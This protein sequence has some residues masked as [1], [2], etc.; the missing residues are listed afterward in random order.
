MTDKYDTLIAEKNFYR[1]LL[2][3]KTDIRKGLKK[4]AVEET[5]KL[6]HYIIS[7]LVENREID[8]ALTLVSNFLD[9]YDKV[10][11]RE[12]SELFLDYLYKIFALLPNK[13]CNKSALKIKILKFFESKEIQDLPVQ[14]YGFYTL[15]SKD[16]IYNKDII[17]GY[18]Y[19]LKSQDYEMLKF[20]IDCY[21]DD[22][23]D[24]NEKGHFIARLCLELILLKNL[25]LALKIVNPYIDSANSYQNNH[26]AV[27]FVFL[28]VNVL[29][30]DQ[31]FENFFK[32]VKM[33]DKKF[34][35]KMFMK[36]V[37]KISQGYYNKQLVSEG[38]ALNIFNLLNSLTN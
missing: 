24:D 11:T 3:V 32:L 26:Y 31:S 25:P 7:V 30:S 8:S 14:R 33:Y 10:Y 35:D 1:L 19:A 36:Y 27:N 9:E 13:E 15:F 17:E 2:N 38:S 22:C 20:F 34:Q 28:L 16:S 23:A 21:L 12:H 6:V 29:T 5:F 37:N 4:G 18:R